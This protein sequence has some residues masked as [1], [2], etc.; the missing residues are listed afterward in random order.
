[1]AGSLP[2]SDSGW[3]FL[4]GIPTTLPCTL[5]AFSHPAP[6]FTSSVPLDVRVGGDA[7]QDHGGGPIVVS[8]CT[9]WGPGALLKAACMPSSPS[10]GESGGEGVEHPVVLMADSWRE[11][12]GPLLEV[13]GRS[14]AVP[15]I[16]LLLVACKGVA[17]TPIPSLGP[18]RG[19]CFILLC[20]WGLSQGNMGVG[21]SRLGF[22]TDRIPD[23]AVGGPVSPSRGLNLSWGTAE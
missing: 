18:L 12:R 19:K 14:F 15:G 1:M 22:H 17:L 20:R 7:T 10:E 5:M 11:V 4:D 3:G 23:H 2:R 9:A 8:R 6:P 13:L 21:G 16:K